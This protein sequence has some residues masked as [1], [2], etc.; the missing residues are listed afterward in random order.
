MDE[1]VP[2]CGVPPVPG[3]IWGR[4]NFDPW[5]VG[6]LALTALLWLIYANRHKSGVAG[7]RNAM[8]WS[9]F[10]ITALAFISPLCAL[11]MALFSARVGQHLVLTLAAAP[12]IAAA[13]PPLPRGRM[14]WIALFATAFWFWHFPAP[15]AATLASDTVYWTMH[16]TLLGA[17]ILF[18][19]GMIGLRDGAIGGAVLGAALSAVQM[20]LFSA[21][22]FFS[23]RSWHGWH[24]TTTWP[25]SLS[26]LEDQQLAALLMWVPGALVFLVILLALAGTWL[27]SALD[28]SDASA[29]PTAQG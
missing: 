11:S 16:L 29:A 19:R 24:E 14:P 10:I 15:Y 3:D 26:P 23:T 28:E 2:Y 12:L 8:F 18:W 6:V 1:R 20:S 21:L 25:W 22:L 9:G 27:A 7:S 4:W 17:A 13:L 5:L